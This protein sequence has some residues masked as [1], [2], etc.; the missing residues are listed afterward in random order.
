M[1]KTCQFNGCTK[2]CYGSYCIR[3]KPR[4]PIKQ[5]GKKTLEYEAWRDNVAKPYLDKKYGRICNA[6]YGN[7]CG[8]EQLDVDHIKNRGSNP[9]LR[10]SLVNV[11]YL[12]RVC[13]R[14][15]TDNKEI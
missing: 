15:K 11:Q 6:C 2:H 9:S 14:L 8:N 1:A 13:H 12:G 7:R 3:H 10:V 4:K 5:K